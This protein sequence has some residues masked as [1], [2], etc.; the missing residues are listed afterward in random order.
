MSEWLEP[1]LSWPEGKR[2]TFFAACR[3]Y[4]E[5]K[6]DLNP[7]QL[8]RFLKEL[9]TRRKIAHQTVYQAVNDLVKDGMLEITVEKP[10]GTGTIKYIKPTEE[11]LKL[12]K[13][14]RVPPVVEFVMGIWE[15]AWNGIVEQLKG[16]T[17]IEN[18]TEQCKLYENKV[19][20][21]VVANLSGWGLAEFLSRLLDKE[22]YPLIPALIELYGQD[23][24]KD[25]SLKKKRIA[26]VDYNI[27]TGGTMKRAKETVIKMGGKPVVAIV[28]FYL[29]KLVKHKIG[30]PVITLIEAPWPYAAIRPISPSSNKP[31]NNF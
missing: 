31:S 1:I 12:Y 20:I 29:P 23:L 14:I 2:I 24:P 15:S 8:Y 11:A 28:A 27:L 19:D 22:V 17:T 4:E 25:P 30:L 21:I 5:K 9:E 13:R 6:Q 16:E 10:F 18:F 26:L 3:Y 7:N